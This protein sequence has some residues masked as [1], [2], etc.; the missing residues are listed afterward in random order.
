MCWHCINI[1]LYFICFM[2]NAESIIKKEKKNFFCSPFHSVVCCS[3]ISF[4]APPNRLVPLSLSLVS[5]MLQH[6]VLCVCVCS[7]SVYDF[8]FLQTLHHSIH[9]RF[10]SSHFQRTRAA[11]VV[12][13]L[14]FIWFISLCVFYLLVSF[15]FG[16]YLVIRS[17]DFFFL[18]Y[19]RWTRTFSFWFANSIQDLDCTMKAK[20]VL[21]IWMFVAFWIYLN[22]N[23]FFCK[24]NAYAVRR[25]SQKHSK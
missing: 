10:L 14:F 7:V 22:G 3:C 1:S 25:V 4:S 12:I 24:F 18:F 17:S 11:G 16:K 20:R 8:R 23:S 5:K 6:L 9:G 15:L 2:L 13:I 21:R 19:Q